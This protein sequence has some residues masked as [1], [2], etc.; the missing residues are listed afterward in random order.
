MKESTIIS[1]HLNIFNN[2]ICEL[3]NIGEKMKDEDKAILLLCILLDSYD[4]LI[5]NLSCTKEDFLDM[6]TVS[7]ALLADE[8]RRKVTLESLESETD[9]FFD[10][11]SSKKM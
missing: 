3:E 10:K 11:R 4:T 9:A 2:I 6:D 1:E 8:L 5:I 7:S